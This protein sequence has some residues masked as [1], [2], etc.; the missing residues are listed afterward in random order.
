MVGRFLVSEVA[1]YAFARAPV[2]RVSQLKEGRSPQSLGK[3]LGA[4]YPLRGGRT[5]SSQR[6]FAAVE[7]LQCE[8]GSKCK[9]S[10]MFMLKMAQAKVSSV[11]SEEGSRFAAV[12]C[13]GSESG[14]LREQS[15]C[16]VI[17]GGGD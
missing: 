12:A 5:R 11:H 2:P 4:V 13:Q 1:L 16:H 9:V 7:P 14:P 10:R 17:S 15:T 8:E 3:Q 6:A